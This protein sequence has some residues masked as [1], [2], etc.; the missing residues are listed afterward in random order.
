MSVTLLLDQA[1]LMKNLHI[2]ELSHQFF[3]SK[4]QSF[5]FPIIEVEREEW[6][7]RDFPVPGDCALEGNEL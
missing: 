6:I 3:F 2:C 4:P 1:L 5:G 7:F